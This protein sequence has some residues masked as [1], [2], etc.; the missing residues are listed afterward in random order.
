MTK[1]DLESKDTEE[2]KRSIA[3]LQISTGIFH[4]SL[5]IYYWILLT[6][7][8]AILDYISKALSLGLDVS[9]IF[10]VLNFFVVFTMVITIFNLILG[11][12]NRMD[13]LKT[14]DLKLISKIIA[15]TTL[16]IFPIGTITAWI[17]LKNLDNN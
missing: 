6:P 14:K 17:V 11:V 1:N 7:I 16:F 3:Y 4:L 8:S 13:Y 10:T 9:F 15:I 12:I 5:I 2:L